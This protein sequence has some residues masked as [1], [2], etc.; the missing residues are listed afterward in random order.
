MLLK[1]QSN[2]HFWS[3]LFLYLPTILITASQKTEPQLEEKG[4][5]IWQTTAKQ[6]NTYNIDAKQL[7]YKQKAQKNNLIPAL[8]PLHAFMKEY[9]PGF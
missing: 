1:H 8:M 9:V 6:T 3:K 5:A 4:K 2:V 7:L